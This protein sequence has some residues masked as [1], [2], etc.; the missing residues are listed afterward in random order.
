MAW[1]VRM[2]PALVVLCAMPAQ[3]QNYPAKPIHVLVPYAPG[4]IADIA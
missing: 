1:F 3:A 2:I 4:G